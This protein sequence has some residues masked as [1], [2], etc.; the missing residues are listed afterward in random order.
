MWVALAT[1]AATVVL[2]FTTTRSR[3]SVANVPPAAAEV[4]A[5]NRFL[6]TVVNTKTPPGP[7]PEGM[8]WIPGGEFSMGAQDPTDMHDAV[9]RATEL[10]E[11]GYASIRQSVFTVKN[12]LV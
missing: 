6:P 2:A 10:G 9:R 8:V 4:A 3:P 12:A 1:I 11:F 5:S 7:A